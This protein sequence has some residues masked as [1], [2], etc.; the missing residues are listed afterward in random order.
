MI[1]AYIWRWLPARP[2]LLLLTVPALIALGVAA[3]APPLVWLERSWPALAVIAPDLETEVARSVLATIAT[4]AMT[5]LALAYSITLV[6]FTLAA[7]AIGPRLLKRFVS[8]RV[9]QTTA[10]LFGGAFLYAIL[11]LAFVTDDRTPN[12]AVLGAMLA[13]VIM[14]LQLVYFV[15]HVAASVSIDDEIAQ[16]AERLRKA[17]AARAARYRPIE[18]PPSE[19]E[20]ATPIKAL[21][22]GYVGA[23]DDAALAALAEEA[24]VMVRV[25]RAPGRFVVEGEPVLLLSQELD[26]AMRDRIGAHV[27]IEAARSESLPIEFSIHLLV[28]IALRALSPGVNDPYTAVAVSDALSGVIADAVANVDASEAVGLVDDDGAPRLI[29]SRIAAR[30][31]IDQAYGPIR[32]SGAGS[33]LMCEAM[34]RAFSRLYVVGDEPVR[35]GV[36]EHTR[37]LLAQMREAPLLPS[38]VDGVVGFLSPPLRE[39]AEAADG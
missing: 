36:V 28:E 30:D 20:F 35:E 33:I 24:D 34:A 25:N 15:R 4:G 13:A 1:G 9:S 3:I 21:R 5:A 14:V 23:I 31:L 27:R 38:D 11:T 8:D 16:I 29:A 10:G 18:D 26:E 39:K 19:D 2:F 32:A 6:V 22:P 37:R 12:V 7:G 17:F